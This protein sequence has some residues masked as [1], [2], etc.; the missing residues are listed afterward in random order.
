M[1][2]EIQLR[3]ADLGDEV[4]WPMHIS[5]RTYSRTLMSLLSSCGFVRSWLRGRQQFGS[6]RSEAKRLDTFLF[7]RSD[8]RRTSSVTRA[9]GMRLIS[10]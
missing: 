9:T 8:A 1:P 5:A 4:Y 6:V 7:A 10:Q 2:D 3:T